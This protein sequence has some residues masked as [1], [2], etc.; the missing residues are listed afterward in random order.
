[1]I[2]KRGE[3]NRRKKLFCWRRVPLPGK[4]FGSHNNNFLVGADIT[5]QVIQTGKLREMI[6]TCTYFRSAL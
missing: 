1:M 4:N 5:V 6:Q 3:T 2:K